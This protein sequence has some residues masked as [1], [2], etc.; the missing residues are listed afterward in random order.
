MD[1]NVKHEICLS[2]QCAIVMK[3]FRISHR[4]CKN[5]DGNYI[6]AYI[7]KAIRTQYGGALGV[8]YDNVFEIDAQNYLT[9]ILIRHADD[10]DEVFQ[11]VL[12]NLKLI[13]SILTRCIG[14]KPFCS[15][16]PVFAFSEL[17]SRIKRSN[18]Q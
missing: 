2:S 13:T 11:S 5:K 7:K 8:A 16:K 6:N 15:R 18:I 9:I 12:W 17:H 14:R 10:G 3:I 1:P 4:Y